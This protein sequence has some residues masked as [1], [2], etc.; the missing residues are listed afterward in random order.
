MGTVTYM[1]P[2]QT[3]G[4]EIDHRSDIWSLG[5]VI[6]QMVVG[7]QPFKGHY[8]KAVMYSITNEEP[9]PMTAL[10]TGVP[11]ELELL[12]NKCLAKDADRR[13]QS[14]ADMVVDLKTL[15]EK[16]KSGKSIIMPAASAQS[17]GARHAAPAPGAPAMTGTHA[18]PTQ[19]QP[20]NP[21]LPGPL[22]KYRVIEDVKESDDSVSYLAE[23]TE[24]HRSVAIRVLPQSSA[25]QIERAQRR[26]Q[27]LA[28]GVGALGLLLALIV[29]F[30]AWW[31]P[32][33]V[34][35]KP[36]RR[37]ALKTDAPPRDPSVS[38]NG[39]HVAYL[40]GNQDRRVL[41]VQDLDQNQPR[42]IVGP[43]NLGDLQPSWSPDSEFICFRMGDDLK[44]VP[45]S[46]GAPVT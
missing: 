36:V 39:R 31:S 10:R 32:V 7:E 44:K 27:T 40:T 16:F 22:A 24:L 21:P 45:V 28:F 2:E 8:D 25:D 46:G 12:V 42:L 35:E 1:S 34:D 14:T 33:P 5:V 20:E 17:V 15:S 29:A 26:K 37:F 4:T 11:M 9:E 23:D 43:G 30:L 41:W 6:Y 19:P 38:P 13:Y 3:Y 18:G